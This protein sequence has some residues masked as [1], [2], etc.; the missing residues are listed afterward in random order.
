MRLLILGL[1]I[2]ILA[3]P[4]AADVISATPSTFDIERQVTINAPLQQSWDVLIAPQKWWSKGQGDPSHA[5]NVSLDV[6]AGG[7]FCEGMPNKG[8]VEH[9]RVVLVMPPRMIRF[10]AALGSL[11]AEAVDGTLTF[12]LDPVGPTTTRLTLVY[13]INGFVRGGAD[14]IA[15]QVDDVLAAQIQ[16]FKTAAEMPPDP[17]PSPAPDAPR[18]QR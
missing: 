9:G 7:C 6:Q 12:Q 1:G 3:G 16:D 5:A 18:R 17:G 8:S 14:T 2:A 11:Q 10:K 4:A 15:A 13:V